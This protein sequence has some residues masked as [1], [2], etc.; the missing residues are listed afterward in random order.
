MLAARM[1][2]LKTASRRSSR[3]ARY[4]AREVSASAC[5]HACTSGWAGVSDEWMREQRDE[6]RHTVTHGGHTS[7]SA[8]VT[9]RRT[10]SRSRFSLSTSCN[11]GSASKSATVPMPARA[12]AACQSES[13]DMRS[14]LRL[15]IVRVVC[16]WLQV[17]C[18]SLFA[19]AGARAPRGDSSGRTTA[20][21]IRDCGYGAGSLRSKSVEGGAEI[22]H[23]IDVSHI[24]GTI[25]GARPLSQALLLQA[26]ERPSSRGQPADEA[27]LSASD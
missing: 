14:S 20:R 27:R 17:E 23:R 22:A 12:R 5:S 18:S 13:L 7:A 24:A 19:Q 16:S 3:V 26:V 9:R 1:P 11:S 6:Q 15:A 8:A 2:P 25:V 10:L 21:S 4:A